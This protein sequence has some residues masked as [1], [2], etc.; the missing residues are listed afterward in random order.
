MWSTMLCKEHVQE[1]ERIVM[2]INCP[3]NMKSTFT[4]TG[5][6]AAIITVN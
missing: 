2:L 3:I 1:I 4:T 5:G 6:D